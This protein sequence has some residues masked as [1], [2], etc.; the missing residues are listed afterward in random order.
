MSDD[1]PTLLRPMKAYS[2]FVSFGQV[3]TVGELITN[4]EYFISID[5]LF[6]VVIFLDLRNLMIPQYDVTVP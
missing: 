5:K 2:F 1:L 6:S 4:S 3:D